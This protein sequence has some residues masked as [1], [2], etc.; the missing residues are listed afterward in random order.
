MH[1]FRI[2]V[3]VAM[4]AESI[5]VRRKTTTLPNRTA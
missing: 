3:A 5:S 4:L 1:S 2:Q